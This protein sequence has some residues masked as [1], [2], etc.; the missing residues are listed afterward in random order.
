MTELLYDDSYAV[1][2]EAIARAV[3]P[4]APLDLPVWS[5]ANVSTPRSSAVPGPYRVAHT[6]YARK[7]LQYLGPRHPCKRVVVKAASQMMKTQVAIN[8]ILGSI[9]CAPANILALEPSDKLAKRLSARLSESIAA[10]PVVAEKVAKP[11]SRD[12][13]NTIDAKDFD[14]GTLYIVTSGSANNLAEIPARYIFLDEVDRMEENLS[15]EGDPV[16][17]AEARATTFAHTAKFYFV[18]SPTVV[19]VSKIDA[20]HEKGTQEVYE[21]PCPHCHEHFELAL[22]NFK[23][24]RDD[25]PLRNVTRAHFVCPHCGGII[26]EASKGWMLMDEEMGGAARWK[27]TAQGDGE[28]VSLHLSAFYAPLGSISWLD[29]AREHAAASDALE[30]GDA[31]AMQVFYNT[32]LALSWDNAVETSSVAELQARASMP[33]RVV[34]KEALV[35]TLSVDVQANRLEAQVEAWGP[36]MEHWV[37][38][39]QV[40][41]GDPATPVTQASS[42]WQRLD[43]LRDT[44]FEHESGEFTLKITEYGI[45]TGGANTQDV[46]NY[47]RQREHKH[48]VLLKGSSRPNRPIISATP[49]NVDVHWNGQRI[50]NGAKLWMIGTDVGKQWLASRMKLQGGPGA[51]HFNTALG[52]EWYEQLLAEKRVIKYLRGRAKVSWEKPN[53]ARNEAWDLANYNLALAHH[54]GLH[55]W[56]QADWERLRERL[57][58]NGAKPA[59]SEQAALQTQPAAAQRPA[60]RRRVFSK[61]I[62]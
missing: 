6:P 38:D 9:A 15:G 44:A 10:C 23:Y 36:D 1:V 8:W 34:P 16:K 31:N 14:G 3:E 52:Q 62:T 55:K 56:T 4:D 45:D 13:R 20:L 53:G 30:K 7:V 57:R 26:G 46:Y 11:R 58:R 48:C 19:G 33:P 61:G 27:E 35:L 54:L 28:T 24:E 2:M 60:A 29:L 5:E 42:V 59:Q 47:G 51:M 40:F 22:E 41:A 49:S 17:I 18:S 39:H 50:E 25:T 43:E 32:R 12:S 37:I 21:V